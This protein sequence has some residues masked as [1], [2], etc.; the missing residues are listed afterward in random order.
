MFGGGAI[1][2]FNRRA[3]AGARSSTLSPLVIYTQEEQLSLKLGGDLYWG[4]GVHH[5]SG[6]MSYRKFPLFFYGIG[7]DSP[8]SSEERYTPEEGL[9]KFIW[10]RRARPGLLLGLGGEIA[11][12]CIVDADSGGLIVGGAL[13]KSEKTR[14]SGVD[15]RIVWDTRDSP[16]FPARGSFHQL[17]FA[18][19]DKSLGSDL[20]YQSYQ[21]D[22]RRYFRVGGS[23]ALVFQALGTAL[24]G[25]PPFSRLAGLGGEDVLRGLYDSRYRDRSRLVIQSELRFMEL[26]GPFGLACF[27]GLGDVAPKPGKLR[28][29]RTRLGAGLGLRYLFV[30]EEKIHIRFDWGLTAKASGFYI[31][32]GEAF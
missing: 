23:G 13:P 29:D 5:L 4:E 25:E 20:E 8:E 28:L 19:Y 14:L 22:L 32:V 26:W 31:T 2:V 12:S 18:T 27:A 15:C 30:S 3:V 7:P 10:L 1:Y 16:H 6:K 11:L 17:L 21:I 9:V 24:A